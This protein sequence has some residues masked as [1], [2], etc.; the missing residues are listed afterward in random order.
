MIWKLPPPLWYNINI[1]GPDIDPQIWYFQI[2]V[3]IE[4]PTITNSTLTIININPID[5]PA[6]DGSV[7]DEVTAIMVG[8]GL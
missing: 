3:L 2:K 6:W 8:E 7:G 4:N 5:W 1:G